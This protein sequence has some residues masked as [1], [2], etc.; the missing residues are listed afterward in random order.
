MSESRA[1]RVSVRRPAAA[2]PPLPMVIVVSAGLF[3]AGIVA[4]LA[5]A[6]GQPYPP[7]L[8]G[9]DTALPSYVA[10][11]ADA[12]RLAG[13]FQFAAA[14]PLAVF[15]ASVVARLQ[16]LGVR[17]AGPTI[18]LSGGL[19]A[20]AAMIVSACAQWTL[21]RA[22]VDSSPALLAALRDLAFV[23]GGPAH[24]VGLGLLIA[25]VAVSSAFTAC[26]PAPS[27]SREPPWR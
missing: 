26:W 3:V 13:L 7:P 23:L 27:G 6:G 11:H 18:A 8:V 24:V 17:A 15:A 4:P 20:S 25:G 14:V 22:P 10:D 5:V 16:A 21:S 12:L 1:G 19:L 9:G 2:G